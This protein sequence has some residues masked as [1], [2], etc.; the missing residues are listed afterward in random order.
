MT[1]AIREVWSLAWPTVVTMLSYTV[2]Q[3]VDA[4]MV[5]LQYLRSSPCCMHVRS[6]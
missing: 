5:D 6:S 1:P 3:F 2:M 4:V